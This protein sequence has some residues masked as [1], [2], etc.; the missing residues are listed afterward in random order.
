[1][2]VGVSIPYLLVVLWMRDFIADMITYLFRIVY[3]THQ[4]KAGSSV[5]PQALVNLSTSIGWYSFRYFKWI[6]E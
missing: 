6:H 1:M 5:M 3:G 2:L 4:V